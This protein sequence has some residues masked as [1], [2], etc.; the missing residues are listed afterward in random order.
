V[1]GIIEA[2]GG[3]VG[4]NGREGGGSI[5]YFELDMKP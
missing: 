3:I 2:H 1:R 5:F 4:V